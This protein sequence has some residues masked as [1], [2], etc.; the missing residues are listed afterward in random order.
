M[1][2]ATSN[3]FSE[4][5][6]LWDIQTGENIRTFEGHLASVFSVAFSLCGKSLM[7]GY[8][9]NNSNWLQFSSI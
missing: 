8:K 9:S 4:A 2:Q 6:N 5:V 1:L 3:S 7:S